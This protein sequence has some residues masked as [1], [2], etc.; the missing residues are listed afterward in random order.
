MSELPQVDHVFAESD[1]SSM[2]ADGD[3]KPSH[4]P[5][6]F[7]SDHVGDTHLAAMSK[8]LRTSL[9]P[10]K[11]HESI[12]A[13]SIASA[14]RSCLNTI[15]LCACSPVATPIPCGFKA[16]RIAACPKISSGAVGSS[17]NLCKRYPLLS[18][19][20]LDRD[21]LTRA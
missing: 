1:T 4:D 10:A 16:F 3:T 19:A 17:M 14:W 2:G 21:S 8:T 7:R 6:A 13:T 5:S 9:T 11:R 12:W 15:R 18:L 20:I